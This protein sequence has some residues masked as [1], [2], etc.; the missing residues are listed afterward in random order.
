MLRC[1][2]IGL[3][4]ADLEELEYGEVI[5]MMTEADNDNAEWNVLATQD[6]FDRF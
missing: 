4:M 3:H 2:Q 5:D 1:F 6:D